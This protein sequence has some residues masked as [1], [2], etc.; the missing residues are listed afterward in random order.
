MSSRDEPL[1]FTSS[2]SP[3][4]VSEQL[5]SLYADPG[6]A[7]LIG[8][9]SNSFQNDTLLSE[10]SG[11]VLSNSCVDAEF[12]FSR[13]EFRLSQLEGTVDFYQRHVFL[14]YKSPV[15]WPPRIEAA[16]FDRLP[17]LLAAAVGSRKADMK[18]Q[19]RLT[20]C[21]GHDGTE[22]S[23]G[24]VLI[25]PDMIRYRRLTHFD[26]DT[27]VE[28]VLVKNGEWQ[29]GTPETLKGWYVFVCSH[30][31]RDRRCGVCG[32]PLVSR[33]KEEI[34]TH[35]LQGKVSVSPCSHIG[36][37]KYAGNVIIFGSNINAK[38]TGHCITGYDEESYDPFSELSI[39]NVCL[40]R[41]YGYVTP[42]DV[43]LLLEQHIGKGEIVDLLWRGQM[44]LSEE[45]QK[46]SQ[47][48][49]LQLNGETNMENSSKEVTL[50]GQLNGEN[51]AA[52]TSQGEFTGCCQQNGDS[53]CQNPVLPEKPDNSAAN[54]KAKVPT[55]KKT[56]SKKLL[57]QS[58]SGKSPSSRKVRTMPTWFESWE[59]EDTY[60][61]LA[62]V[63]AAVSVFVAYSCYKQLG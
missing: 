31:S 48:L 16:E 61:T 26:V 30:G 38:I 62:V 58:S 43:P 63:C 12:G 24:D 36:G 6:S 50:Q 23:N 22:T 7:S 60:A 2:S 28:E 45:E 14:C 13:P 21:E 11:S 19:T 49:R 52:C 37:H 57:S 4:T 29:P 27:F 33:F 9:A 10:G 55:E 54:E 5:D 17:R 40:V 46:K 39:K 53:C 59:R 56:S 18:R 44:G 20:I 34:E 25:F 47:E 32:P 15:V 51:T 41:K 35:G 1:N 3:I 42:D 8:S